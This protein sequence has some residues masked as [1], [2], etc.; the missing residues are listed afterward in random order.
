MKKLFAVLTLALVLAPLAAHADPVTVNG[1]GTYY[2]GG[3]IHTP[4]SSPLGHINGDFSIGQTAI[5]WNGQTYVGYCV[6]PFDDF[7][8]GNPWTATQRRM[9]QLSMGGPEGHTFNPPYTAAN[10]GAHAAWIVNTYAPTV[11]S[12]DDA[13]ALQVALWLTF[14]PGLKTSWF[15]FGS[16]SN[17]IRTQAWHWYNEGANQTSDAIWLDAQHEDRALDLVIPQA[18]PEP[19]SMILLGTGMLGLAGVLR[20]RLDKKR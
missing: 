19:A 20:R 12:G 11:D 3:S 2:R 5:T 14:F 17:D 8:P 18:V 15:E 6:E 16:H 1:M 7:D 4:T 13:A 10:A 9:S